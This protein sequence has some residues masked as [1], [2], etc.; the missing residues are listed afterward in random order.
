MTKEQVLDIVERVINIV[1]EKG[2]ESSMHS[3]IGLFSTYEE[4]EN[5]SIKFT[6]EKLKVV[7]GLLSEDYKIGYREGIEHYLAS[8]NN[9]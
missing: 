2:K 9:L 8:K 7:N 5:E 1:F 4:C 3:I 6:N